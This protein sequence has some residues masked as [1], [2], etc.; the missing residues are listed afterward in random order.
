M[1]NTGDFRRY[2]YGTD[3]S[4]ALKAFDVSRSSTA[5]AYKPKRERDLKVHEN[6]KRKSKTELLKEQRE[7]AVKAAIIFS[8]AV[9]TIAMLFG[10][11][12]TNAKK[13]E[14]RHEINN[15]NTELSIAQSENTRI[16]SELNALVSMNMIEKYAVEELGMVKVQ[17][18]QIHY[19]DVSQFKEEQ[20]SA[21]QNEELPPEASEQVAE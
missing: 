6:V 11:L 12:Y 15:L 20:L 5:P 18:G 3:A 8:V 10:M 9:L 1:T 2:S 21:T 19:I 4:Y 17:S 13:N 7:S 16:N 14:L